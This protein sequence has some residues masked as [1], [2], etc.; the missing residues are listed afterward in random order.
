MIAPQPR[1]GFAVSDQ[2]MPSHFDSQNLD[3]D[4]SG[5]GPVVPE[6]S[7][8]QACPACEV[9]LDISDCEPLEKIVCPQC[10]TV[11]L[12]NGQI[13]HYVISEVAGR[14]GMGVVYKAYDPSLDRNVAIK[15]LRKDQS[16]DEKVIRQFETE[17]AITAGV[18][19]ANVVRVFGT[20]VDRGR[21]YLVM[22]LVEKGSL[23]TLIQLQGRVAEAQ[24]LQ[25]GVQIAK[26]LRA[27][28]EHGLIH[29]DVKPG[30]ILFSDANTAKIVD[31]GLAVFQK[32]E[33]S[34][35]G[36]VW[37]TPYYVAPE[38]LA[39]EPEDFRSDMYSLGGT[40]FHALAGRP[41]FEAENASLVA[42]KHLKSQQ[43]SIQSFAPWVSNS[44]AHIIN[45][46]LNKDPE[47]RFQ[48]YDE[49][50]ESFDY[51]LTQLHAHG[52]A[53]AARARAKLETEEDQ[54]RYTWVFLGFAAVVLILGAVFGIS[55]WKK[56]A[57]GAKTVARAAVRTGARY[58]PLQEGIEALAAGKPEA[59]DLFKKAAENPQLS[60]AD[61]A[62]AQLFAGTA[63]LAIG[64]TNEARNTFTHVAETAA[65]LKDKPLGEL[66]AEIASRVSESRPVA[67][68]VARL[69]T[70]GHEGVALLIY[71]LHDWH[72]GKGDDAVVMFKQFRNIEP[73]GTAQWIGHLKPLAVSFI[74]KETALQ[75][76]TA[77]LKAATAPGDRNSAAESLRSI[78]PVFS[79][80]AEDAIAPY[81]EEIAKYKAE[82]A[83]Y[84]AEISKPPTSGIFLIANRGSGKIL[85]VSGSSMSPGAK[86]NISDGGSAFNQWW[87]VIPLGQDKVK[88]SAMHSDKMLAVEGDGSAENAK[89]IQADNNNLPTQQWLL[90]SKGDGGFKLRNEASG[91]I[92][93]VEGDKRD[94][95]T[96]A[97]VRADG[98]K[99][100]RRFE[101]EWRFLRRGTPVGEFTG[102][103]VGGGKGT[104]EFKDGTYTIRDTS[105]DIWGTSDQFGFA[106][107]EITDDFEIVARIAEIANAQSNGK[108]G[109]MVRAGL[110][111]DEPC[112]SALLLP[113]TTGNPPEIVTAAV[114]Q[115]Q[116]L[117]KNT[118][119]KA[120]KIA[121]Q[122][123]PRWLKLVR[124]GNTVTSSYSADGAAWQHAGTA[125]IEGMERVA[126]AGL[127]VTGQNGD[128]EI[129][130]KFDQVK[131]TPLKK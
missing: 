66:I 99:G 12:V 8:L 71:A 87:K 43:V 86:V 56:P 61:R 44:T 13:A 41:P 106:F 42:L 75:V 112:V 26:G 128:K 48:T 80:H 34:V 95:G 103:P 5:A 63:Q 94:N 50:I 45:R 108:V 70:T 69:D 119:I 76:G 36:E 79:K 23:D 104:F 65:V 83:K 29:R 84:E 33:E 123:L 25:V 73:Q 17:A 20:G 27:A 110:G 18:A 67:T 92:L 74:E 102:H 91:K 55:Q 100:E 19:D 129:T 21:F 125:T 60:P 37:G 40:L 88:L 52:G 2:T 117:K 1:T 24:V 31:F 51:A 114:S 54:K 109:I 72:V 97:I 11:M 81:R 98:D 28:C 47:Q 30:N 96:A 105:R 35:R 82:I 39:Q 14:G 38:K 113:S 124:V 58:E 89:V 116:R 121:N 127:A 9:L 68:T 126:F 130:A 77:R 49:L 93:A 3:L 53:S 131:I 78:D 118:A 6:N 32:Q 120:N 57:P 16:A 101:W 59:V 85:D 64:K 90:I 115:H 7:P 62:W 111:G 4:R 15:L 10:G 22:E 46:M 107:R 122:P